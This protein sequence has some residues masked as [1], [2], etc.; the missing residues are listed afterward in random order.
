MT[1]RQSQTC[2][3]SSIFRDVM[4]YYPGTAHGPAPTQKYPAISGPPQADPVPPTAWPV[5]DPNSHK[6]PFL[7]PASSGS[8]IVDPGPA[9][10]PLLAERPFKLWERQSIARDQHWYLDPRE[11]EYEGSIY[12]YEWKYYEG[13]LQQEHFIPKA[14]VEKLMQGFNLTSNDRNDILNE[15]AN[16][17]FLPPLLNIYKSSQLP[18]EW[19]HAGGVPISAQFREDARGAGEYILDVLNREIWKRHTINENLRKRIKGPPLR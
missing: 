3:E 15:I 9:P 13:T 2:N 17:F 6:S 8:A 18:W 5:S 12:N 14:H 10:T 11:G 1:P 7:D 4:V 16:L 19:Y